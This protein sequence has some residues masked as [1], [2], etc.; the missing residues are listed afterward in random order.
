MTREVNNYK[1]TFLAL[2][3]LL[4]IS[5]VTVTFVHT[6]NFLQSNFGNAATIINQEQKQ[7]PLPSAVTD[8]NQTD[9]SN[10]T[11]LNSNYSSTPLSTGPTSLDTAKSATYK[12]PD[13]TQFFSSLFYH[14]NQGQTP[15]SDISADPV[16]LDTTK[17]ETYTY[18]GDLVQQLDSAQFFFSYPNNTNYGQIAGSDAI[19]PNTYVI[20]KIDFDA[21]FNTPKISALGFDEMAIFASSNTITYK[22]TEFGIR[23]D[24]K[25]GFID[26][27][28]QESNGNYGEVNFQMIKLIP[29]DGTIHHYTLVAIGSDVS[30]RI[31]GINYGYLNF[32]SNTDSS[33]FSFSICA[34]VHRFSD[35]WDSIG[36]NMTT[37]N[38]WLNQQ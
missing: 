7:S 1:N 4:I 8:N 3:I 16:F 32:A 17:F 36:N 24:L 9:T 34:V 19:T 6:S 12:Q 5:V 18:G 25:D 22:G 33:S 15:Q 21:A 20:Q 27:Y 23:M 30:F 35:N 10:V 11:N 31:D 2:T 14:L 13:P 28:V 26:G 29:N 37:G 38:F